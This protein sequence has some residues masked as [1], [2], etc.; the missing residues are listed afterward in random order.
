MVWRYISVNHLST[1]NG[2]QG[3]TC[4]LSFISSLWKCKGRCRTHFQR[5]GLRARRQNLAVS[6]CKQNLQHLKFPS[7]NWRFPSQLNPMFAIHSASRIWIRNSENAKQLHLKL[8]VFLQLPRLSSVI[9]ASPSF[10][11]MYLYQL[12]LCEN[13]HY[14][15][16]LNITKK[17]EEWEQLSIFL[18]RPWL[19]S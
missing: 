2:S 10:N 9:L 1:V 15:Q 4:S 19:A 13:D 5:W 11:K 17:M 18:C 3:N 12:H 7:C 14:K 16:W 8:C 6:L